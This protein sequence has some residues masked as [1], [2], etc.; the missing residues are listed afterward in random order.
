MRADLTPSHVRAHIEPSGRIL[1]ATLGPH[2]TA[3]G[4]DYDIPSADA[5][6]VSAL[7]RWALCELAES[8]AA[9]RGRPS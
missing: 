8:I 4:T 3:I 6:T 5:R 7:W 9:E 1:V 2:R